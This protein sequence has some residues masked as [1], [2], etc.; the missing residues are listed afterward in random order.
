[1]KKLITLMLLFLIVMLIGCN[2][3]EKNK[4]ARNSV[5]VLFEKLENIA[6]VKE[7]GTDLVYVIAD[8]ERIEEIKKLIYDSVESLKLITEDDIGEIP[9]GAF[10]DASLL[11]LYG[12]SGMWIDVY[13]N[14]ESMP[15][16][17][18]CIYHSSAYS[19]EYYG[20]NLNGPIYQE[21]NRIMHTGERKRMGD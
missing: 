2:S 1:M 21:I 4:E 17:L 8:Q 14:Y 19:R 20:Y 15:A 7:M 6:M 12:D 5:T 10:N 16:D 11:T 9:V 13:I 18:V 3:G